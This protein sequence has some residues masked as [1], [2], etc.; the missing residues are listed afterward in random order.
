MTPNCEGIW[1]WFEKDGTKR[2]VEVVNVYKNIGETCLRVYWNGSYYNVSD[3][4]ED[5]Y[6]MDGSIFEKNVLVKAEWVSGTWGNRVANNG[7][8]PD[9]LMYLYRN[10]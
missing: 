2:L 5:L 7:E 8:L 4:Y 10:S 1:E 9:D 6:N 3:R